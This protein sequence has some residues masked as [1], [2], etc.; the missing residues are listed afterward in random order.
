MTS[1]GDEG[2]HVLQ[3]YLLVEVGMGSARAAV[4]AL[5]QID[6]VRCADAVTGP[7]D[8]V[9][10]IEAAD[11]DVLGALVQERVQQ[12]PGVVR[13]ITCPVFHL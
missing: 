11:V 7:Y 5:R 2:T 6:G 13:T 4:A 10:D 3:A 12:V 1:V 9:I 8:V